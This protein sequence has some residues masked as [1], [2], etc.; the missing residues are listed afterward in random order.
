ML[1]FVIYT[2]DLPAVIQRL[3]I[4]HHPYADETQ[5]SDELPITSIVA[6]ISNMEHG[7]DTVYAWSSAKWLQL[8]PSKSEIIKRLENTNLILHIETDMVTPSNIVRDLGI[9]LDSE[10]TIRQHISKIVGVCFYH[11][12][13]LKKVRRILGSSITCRLITAFVMSCLNYCNALLA[14]L[15]QSTIVLLQRVQNASVCLVSGLQPRDHVTSSL[16]ELHWLSIRYRIIYKLCLMMHNAHVGR[17]SRYIIDTHLLIVN[18]PNRGRLRSSAANKYEL[19]ALRLKIGDR[20]FSY[21]G[22]CRAN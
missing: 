6:S 11:L 9:L 1:K 3:A 8:N 19:P 10:L 7:N 18:M 4:E 13:R 14:G 2:E 22:P 16:R 12:R 15:P 17:S 5:L 20:A 21:S